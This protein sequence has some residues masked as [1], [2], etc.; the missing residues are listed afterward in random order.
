M[1]QTSKRY[2]AVVIGGGI[3]GLTCATHLAKNGVRTVRI[4]PDDSSM[5]GRPRRYYVQLTAQRNVE[6]AEDRLAEIRE[7][8]PD[9]LGRREPVIR[10][11]VAGVN[12]IYRALVGP[13]DL[14]GANE[15][16]DGLKAQGG[17][18]VV[19]WIDPDE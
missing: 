5:P 7:R 2:D 18:C 15:M 1:T 9:A 19:H 17:Q 3:N 16:C 13:F 10:R 12:V 14:G 6:D 11:T 8:F 4:H